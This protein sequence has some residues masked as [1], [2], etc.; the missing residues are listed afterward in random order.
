[1][2]QFRCH[3]HFRLYQRAYIWTSIEASHSRQRRPFSSQPGTVN[4]AFLLAFP[5]MPAI[6]TVNVD[7]LR[8]GEDVGRSF[9]DGS[10]T[11]EVDKICRSIVA[12]ILCSRRVRRD[13][14]LFI[15]FG[16]A[17]NGEVSSLQLAGSSIRKLYA[18][19]R[20]MATMLA[21]FLAQNPATESSSK[22][23]NRSANIRS[24][25]WRQLGLEKM[26]V[27]RNARVF[28]LRQDAAL[29][30]ED[31]ILAAKRD[32]VGQLVFL[33][34]QSAAE[35]YRRTEGE[36]LEVS[37]GD[38]PRVGSHC[39]TILQYLIDQH[40]TPVTARTN[41]SLQQAKS[42]VEQQQQQQQQQ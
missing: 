20:W 38:I 4:R 3:R 17:S 13:S 15:Q 12:S 14:D 39:I 31:A 24:L 35:E 28:L 41:E 2:L 10:A 1:M 40:W 27:H 34:G 23:P 9:C 11:E 32:G 8:A 19:K 5:S 26:K 18:D 37:L 33:I 29:D 6:P 16:C 36:F 22:D 25:G 42:E 21:R 30:A 7:A